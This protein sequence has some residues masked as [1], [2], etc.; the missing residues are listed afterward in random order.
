MVASRS[1]RTPWVRSRSSGRRWPASTQITT[2]RYAWEA[3]SGFTA[4]LAPR[5][6]QG[7]CR[8]RDVFGTRNFSWEEIVE[9]RPVED[10]VIDRL[11][12]YVSAN[13]AFTK[14]SGV[15]QTEFRANASYQDERAQNDLTSRIT[16]SDT[17]EDS[18]SSSRLN[19][20][21]KAWT[22]RAGIFRT[23][24][25]GH[26]T[27]DELGL[28]YRLTLGGGFG[29]FILDSNNQTMTGVIA[30]Q[31]L[32]ERSVGGDSQQSMEA[33]L[34]AQFARWRFDTPELD[35]RIDAQLYP[36]LTERGRLRAD[37]N[38]TIRWELI[39]DLYWNFSA[40]GAYDNA[41][42]EEEAGEFDWGVTT[43]VGWEF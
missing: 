13:Y 17:D 38:A 12:I 4:P 35:F 14:A 42:V 25:G 33:V 11:N 41:A 40:W 28:D 32:E 10:T 37:T 3:A 2:M 1:A 7:A 6:F 18:S 9:L 26:E 20:S 36:S 19:L 27:N 22:D 21:R 39:S 15:T 43:G 34:A 23:F 30:L 5:R 29:R 8:S 16:V 31:A 24:F